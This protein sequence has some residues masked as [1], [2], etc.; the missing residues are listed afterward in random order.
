MFAP[1]GG[2]S[3]LR[4]AATVAPLMPRD[5]S[6]EEIRRYLGEEHGCWLTHAEDGDV[7]EG[8]ASGGTT[9][10]LLINMLEGGHVDGV[11]VWRMA[12]DGARPYAEPF[13]ATR[14]EEVLSARG[15]KYTA[16]SYPKQAMPV[17][18]AFDGRLAV[19]AVPCDASYLRRKMKRDPALERKI[20][21]VVTLFCGH[22]SEPA[23]TEL[24]VRKHGMDW[25]DVRSFRYRT[26]KWRGRLTFESHDG[27]SVDIP[28]R[29]FTHYQNLHLF[30]ERKCLNCVDHF[31]FD[32]DI[33]TG[34]I[35]SLAH[36]K[37]EVKPTLVVAKTERGR[38]LL[39]ACWEGVAREEVS[40]HVV[41]DGNSRGMT[42]H[43]HL[44]ARA[45]AGRPLGVKIRDPL[46]LPVTPLDRAVASVGVFNYWWSHHPRYGALVEK[47]PFG[48]IQAYIYAFKGL[49]QLNLFLYR[50]FPP[51]DKV[52]I[53]GATVTGNRGAEA[54]LVTTLGRVRDA[55]PDARFVVHSYFPERDREL[56]SDLGVEVVDATPLAL[57]TQYFPF[58]IAD[59]VL[60][61]VGLGVPRSWMPRNVRELKESRVLVDVF[62]VSYSD[63]REKFLPFNVLSNWPAMLLGTPVVKL[64]QALGGYDG[65]LN[66]A[67]AKWMLG[68]TAKVF[69]RGRASEAMTRALGLKEETLGFAPDVAFAYEPRYALSDENPAFRDATVARLR[70]LRAG[71]DEVLVLSVSAVVRQKCKKR[72][73]DYEAVMAEVTRR[74]LARGLV[75]A[76]FPNATREGTDSL[77]NND[78]PIIAEIASRVG[79]DERLVLVDRDLNTAGLRAVLAEA[80]YLVASRFHAMIAGL[81]LGVPTMVLGWGHKYAEVLEQLEIGEHAYDYTSLDADSLLTRIDA[82]LERSDDVA[83]RIRRNIERVKAESAAQFDWL[84]SFLVPRLEVCTPDDAETPERPEPLRREP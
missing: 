75:V 59:G 22:N 7:R 35:W 21:C 37:R 57:V 73:L 80:D 64:S 33:C 2:V 79:N 31:G 45:E 32:G 52:S 34:D 30:S 28:T 61:K 77:H 58:S 4:P 8:A 76:L 11:L 25:A 53:I 60:S 19:V 82:F 50:P 40:P 23:L 9:S 41:L 15:S 46:R 81:C 42:Y 66:R 83:A 68:K 39:D 65:K 43:Y 3:T 71:G 74:L 5:W 67:V 12:T 1:A 47:L 62:G 69:A 18:E 26:G 16:V 20:R 14:R 29:T 84:V 36:R 54:M 38:A 13:V 49:Q 78:L 56:V 24:I 48:A 44:S 10:Q 70:E 6:K 27:R 51:E 63:G 55:L 72:G 17:I